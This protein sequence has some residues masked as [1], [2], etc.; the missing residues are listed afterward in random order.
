MNGNKVAPKYFY[1]PL[2][3]EKLE[4]RFLLFEMICLP[5]VLAQVN[6]DFTWVLACSSQ[7]PSKYYEKYE[8]PH[9]ARHLDEVNMGF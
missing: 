4:F 5:N 9:L 3:P 7:N 1:D 6:K 8:D 2:S